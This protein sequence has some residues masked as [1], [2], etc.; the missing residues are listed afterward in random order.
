MTAKE[1][2]VINYLIIGSIVFVVCSIVCT[3]CNPESIYGGL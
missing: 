2:K 1:K 3:L